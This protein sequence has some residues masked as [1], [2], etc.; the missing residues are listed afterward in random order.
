MQKSV[1]GGVERGCFVL[2]YRNVFTLNTKGG[3][4]GGGGL[5]L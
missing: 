3:S 1:V 4:R 2:S 5:Y